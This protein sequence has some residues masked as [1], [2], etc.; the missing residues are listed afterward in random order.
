MAKVEVYTTDYCPYCTRAKQL[1][2]MK[3]VDY[4]EIDVSS[5]D[6]ARIALVQKAQGRRTVP[7]IFINDKPI[8]GYDDMRALE[9]SGDLDKLLAE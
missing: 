3:D 7:Q 1:L 6:A 2:D 9:D 4:A 5:D 8:G